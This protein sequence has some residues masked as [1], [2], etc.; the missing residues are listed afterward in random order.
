MLS[1]ER[2]DLKTKSFTRD[3]RDIYESK[4]DQFIRKT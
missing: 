2:V 3:Q 1:L 4:E